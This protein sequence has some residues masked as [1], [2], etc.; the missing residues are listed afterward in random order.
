M[1]SG[2]SSGPA[3]IVEDVDA[4]LVVQRVRERQCPPQADIGEAGIEP[5]TPAELAVVENWIAAGAPLVD[6][7]HEV[8]AGDDDPLVSSDDRQFWSFRPPERP[9]IPSVEQAELVNNPIDAFLLSRLE[10]EGL[11]YSPEAERLALLR[12]ATFALTGLSARTGRDRRLAQRRPAE[13]LGSA[14]R[15]AVGLPALRRAPGTVLAGSGRI[16]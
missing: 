12:R 1:L 16:R 15:S 11:S 3:F 4:S 2:G 5:M 14:R 8:A 13:C 10:E 6:L 7:A 9:D